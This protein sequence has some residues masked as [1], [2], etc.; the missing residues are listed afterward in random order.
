MRRDIK[1]TDTGRKVTVK[2][3]VKA[4]SLAAV[5]R[6]FPIELMLTDWSIKYPGSK[7]YEY[8]TVIKG[9]S[10][11]EAGAILK[12]VPV[13][14]WY[15][16]KCELLDGITAGLAKRQIDW[17][18]E[19]HDL[20]FEGS[21]I[22]MMSAMDWI[23]H[24]DTQPIEN[25]DIRMVKVAVETIQVAQRIQRTALGLPSDDG[26][27]HIYNQLI[28]KQQQAKHISEDEK[29]PVEKLEERLTMADIRALI[30]VRRVEKANEVIEAEGH[31]VGS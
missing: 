31:A 17:A 14:D 5:E 30:E 7:P 16:A 9:Y 8:L 3:K 26:A 23:R 1:A 4:A 19:M 2:T 25:R 29:T 27:I 24:Q 18:A 13:P 10:R 11:S 20:H 28:I 21:K 6:E 12:R 15:T 22:G